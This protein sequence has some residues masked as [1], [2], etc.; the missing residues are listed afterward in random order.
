MY[1]DRNGKEYHYWRKANAIHNF[2]VNEVQDGVDDCNS[3]NVPKS[4]IEDLAERCDLV[5][6]ILDKCPRKEAEYC[7][8]YQRND[9]GEMVKMYDTYTVYDVEDNSEIQNLLPTQCGFFFGSTEYD[10]YYRNMILETKEMCDDL[11]AT[12][13]WDKEEL[14]Y[15]S[16]W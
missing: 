16:S 13:D 5:L 9:Q 15:G 8:G 6:Q 12:M 2:F 3:Y 4:V 7:C 14:T 11:L 1:L 10:E